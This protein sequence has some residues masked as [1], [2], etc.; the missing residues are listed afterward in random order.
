MA[1][2][3][4]GDSLA[5]RFS[6]TA[7]LCSSPS[8]A[9]WVKLPLSGKQQA[10]ADCCNYDSLVTRTMDRIDGLAMIVL[11]H[12][13]SAVTVTAHQ[14]ASAALDQPPFKRLHELVVCV[15]LL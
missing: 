1:A 15:T 13:Y 11:R 3:S 6:A 10:A 14:N 7:K 9:T 8:A 5:Q 12:F 4:T 2:T